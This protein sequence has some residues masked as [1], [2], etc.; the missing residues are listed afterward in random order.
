VTAKLEIFWNL[1]STE[2]LKKLETS[3]SGLAIGE[4][5][6]RLSL[7]GPNIL[8]PK[9]RFTAFLI[10]ITQF[11]SPIILILIL[12]AGLSFFLKDPSDAV[13]ILSIVMISSI[14]GFWQEFKA[15]ATINKL[16]E[17]IRI[18]V[19]VLRDNRDTEIPLEE[20]VPGEIIILNAGDIIP[21]DCLIIES[22]DL[23]VNESTLTGETYPSEKQEGI[24]FLETPVSKRTNC[25]FM[26][27]NVV[28]GTGK[29]VVVNTGKSTEFGKISE[30]LNLKSP[31]T[32]F[33]HSIKRFGYFLMEVTTVL[34][35]VIFAINIFLKRP[36]LDSFLFSLALAV[37]LT[38]QLLPAIISVNLARGAKRLAEIKVVVKHLSSIENFGSM[39]VFC[40]DKTGTLTEGIM[41]FNS[42]I[43]IFGI[44]SDKVL[45]YAYINAFYE[46]GFV[47]PIDET[48]RNLKE[49]DLS[50]HLKLDEI[51]YDFI[52]KRL[53]ILVSSE[54]N[55]IM[56]TKGAFD[57]ILEICSHSESENGVLI[58]IE[59]VKDKIKKIFEDYSN[60]GLRTLGI[61][62]KNIGRNSSIAKE[63]ESEMI[64]LG[65]LTFEDKPKEG[66]S[67]TISE[68]KKLG[69]IL[70]IITGD[71]IKVAANMA[72]KAGLQNP[73]IITGSE[74]NKIIDEALLK[75]VNDIGV[76]AEV[77]PNQKERIII[78]LK[79]AGNVVGYM[80][81]GINDA[82]ALHASDVSIS[83]NGAADIAKESADIVLLDKDLRVLSKGIK[84]GR[85][86]FSNTLKYIY[87]A[88]S[89]NFG[90]MFSMAGASL[91]LSF[92]PLLPK[93]ILLTNLMTDF[94]EMTIAIDNVDKEMSDV[95]RR[96][97]MKFIRN[98]MLTFGLI[99][100]I[101]DF[102][103][104]GILLLLMHAST[105]QFR[106]G[107]FLE[108]V[109][110]AA[111]IV[112]AIRT[113]R[114]I[115]K[116]K[117]GK[118]LLVSTLLILAVTLF[119][120]YTSLGTI[121]GFE[122]LP[123]TFILVLA[124]ILISYIIVV[125]IVKKIFYKKVRY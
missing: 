21:A 70:K 48:I 29:A 5:Q 8:K 85:A 83:V 76:F 105:E 13:I 3:T 98:F 65:F 111:I 16:L 92:L 27:T 69:V 86:I 114:S 39:N 82:S 47:N 57:N 124:V 6:N 2:V 33:E 40:S 52:R 44:K 66:I 117:P 59:E 46:K 11:K 12:A 54:N 25:L 95:P 73:K 107:W 74:L 102:A 110:S 35:I 51:P 91:F 49:F 34:V 22:E 55:N 38:P 96:F 118:Y 45:F 32:E 23:F 120:P 77:E 103:T 109:I 104:F 56:I 19:N 101:F 26:G 4:A 84:E 31:E 97:N 81:D 64:F 41:N 72:K 80:G 87:M 100:S 78:A 119:L 30:R 121:F 88:T 71:N 62:Y 125:E 60:Q 24:L 43:D 67:E 75:I 20:I 18:K 9:K 68:L 1:N 53:S 106:T 17:T 61:A 28:S 63:N 89:A 93:Q 36:F 108:S 112:L 115:F 94:P 79:K 42:A 10:F 50:K 99:S 15:T 58:K 122:P 113:R 123:L 37:G 90:N 116:S 14:L 7:Y